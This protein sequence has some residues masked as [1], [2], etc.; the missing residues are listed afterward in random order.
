MSETA[1]LLRPAE[2]TLE[3]VEVHVAASRVGSPGCSSKTV[4]KVPHTM[5]FE[6]L[7]NQQVGAGQWPFAKFKFEA[8]SIKWR[9]LWCGRQYRCY[10]SCPTVK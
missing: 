3:T 8:C 10:V 4:V 9:A 1:T 2:R 7:R 6:V 5:I